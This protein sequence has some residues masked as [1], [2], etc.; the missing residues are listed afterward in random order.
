MKTKVIYGRNERLGD[1]YTDAGVG[2]Q[3]YKHFLHEHRLV[4]V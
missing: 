2:Y 1:Y 4:L 3:V